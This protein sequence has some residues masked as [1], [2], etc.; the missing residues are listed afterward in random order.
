M[1]T[2]KN[3]TIGWGLIGC[4]V[5]AP[6]H[7]KAIKEVK[8]AKLV[9]CCDVVK[10]R[11]EACA[12]E[13]GTTRTKVY[14]DLEKMLEDPNVDAV[15]VCTPSGMHADNGIMAA[16]AAKHILCEKP[17]DV[18]LHKIDALIAAA[19]DNNVKLAGVF[20]RRT[21]AINK[22][23]REAVRCGTLGKL[24]LGCSY[25]KYF[26]SHEYYASGDWRATWELDGG[27]ALMN[28]GVH[29]IDLL[30]FL[31][32]DIKRLSA[33][34]RTLVRNIEVEDTAIATV[35]FVNGAL[36][37]IEGTTSVTPGMGCN[38]TICGDAGT[39]VLEGDKLTLWDVPGAEDA[40][41][42]EEKADNGAA[43]DAKAGLGAQGHVAHIGDLVDAIW[44]D[45]EPAIPGREARRAVE[46]IKAIYLSARRGGDNVELPL[47]YEDDGP[48]IDYQAARSA[49]WDI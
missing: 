40:M 3:N 44:N 21:Y 4:G 22:E 12:K 7:A 28:Q 2:A 37:T 19:A 5:I 10:E 13:H 16:Q 45:R 31:M 15:S 41:E 32:G 42:A 24:V 34:C 48:G 39:I 14:T 20:Q 17:M 9:A 43:R 8:G 35:E 29:G 33:R 47:S 27:G 49:E 38:T 18:S 30:L 11:A 1:A 26:R 6:T 25:Q 36:G 46:V 23:V